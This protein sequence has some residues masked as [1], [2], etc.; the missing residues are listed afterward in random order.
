MNSTC[1]CLYIKLGINFFHYVR[2]IKITFLDFYFYSN[3]LLIKFKP[4]ILSLT[5]FSVK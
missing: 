4:N 1:V 3:P 2:M 5:P